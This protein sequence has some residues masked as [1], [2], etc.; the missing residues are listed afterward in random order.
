MGP[1]RTLTWLT[2]QF[3][4]HLLALRLW[5]GPA[6]QKVEPL[7]VCRVGHKHQDWEEQECQDRLPQLHLEEK[8]EF[9]ISERFREYVKLKA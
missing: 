9:F 3:D 6:E 7:L 4:L 2:T 5:L 1:I 8:A